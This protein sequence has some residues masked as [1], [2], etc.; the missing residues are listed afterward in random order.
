MDVHASNLDPVATA[1]GR[2]GRTNEVNIDLDGFQRRRDLE[3]IS[4]QEEYLLEKVSTPTFIRSSVQ[5][6][7]TRR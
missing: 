6:P 3:S 7:H 2:Y 4:N 5:A 1:H